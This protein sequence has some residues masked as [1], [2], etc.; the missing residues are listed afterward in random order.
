MCSE[1]E[2]RDL[3]YPVIARALDPLAPYAAISLSLRLYPELRAPEAQQSP[4]HDGE[5]L[6]QEVPLVMGLVA[7][8]RSVSVILFD[9]SC[10]INLFTIFIIFIYMVHLLQLLVPIGVYGP[11]T[12]T[13]RTQQSQ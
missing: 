11:I 6:L 5:L 10:F 4:D 9:F 12:T 2:S 3:L 13:R 1:W 8:E 7:L